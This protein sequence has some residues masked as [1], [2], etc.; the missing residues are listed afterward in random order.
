MTRRA[1]YGFGLLFTVVCTLM[2]VESINI[3]RWVSYNPTAR[4]HYSMG[5]HRRCSSVT[6]TCEPFPRPSDCVDSRAGFCDLWR[7]V[8]FLV[9]LSVVVELAT[10]VS[11]VVIIAGGVQRRAAGWK[12]ISS[13]L[14]FG[15]AV[16][17]AGT[18]I[19]AHLSSTDDRFARGWQLDLSWRLCTASWIIMAAAAS[20]IAASA[21]YLP[22][23][24][25]YETIPDNPMSYEQDE[26]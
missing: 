19:V 6:G 20:V 23:E 15:A 12:I 25:E 14:G 24:D 1:V 2:T 9:S 17:C 10:I 16:Q 3:P 11:F 22:E 7:S 13:I 4:R 26:L 18:A 21:R 8:G 5:L